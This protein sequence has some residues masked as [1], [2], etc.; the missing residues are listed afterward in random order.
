LFKGVHPPVVLPGGFVDDAE[1]P[2]RDGHELFENSQGHPDLPSLLLKLREVTLRLGL[3]QVYGTGLRCLSG[4]R[5]DTNAAWP[6]HFFLS[7]QDVA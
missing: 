6:I 3:R 2:L 7:K 1:G 4:P 5:T